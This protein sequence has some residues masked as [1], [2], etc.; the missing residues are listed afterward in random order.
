MPL[1]SATVNAITAQLQATTAKLAAVADAIDVSSETLAV[2]NTD[3]TAHPPIQAMIDAIDAVNTSDL[4]S[5]I[6]AHDTSTT[7]HEDIRTL[8]S[9]LSSSGG[10]AD[11]TTVT[12]DIA[13]AVTTHNTSTS[14][15]EDLRTQ[16]SASTTQLAAISS[17]IAAGSTS[18]DIAVHN[19]DPLAH[20]S[21][22]A[23]LS[24]INTEMEVVTA[25]SSYI[26]Q[27][28]SLFNGTLSTGGGSSGGGSSGSGAVSTGDSATTNANTAAI[29]TLEASLAGSQQAVN[30]LGSQMVN[31]T[32]ALS[33]QAVA[34]KQLEINNSFID[35]GVSL[36]GFADTLASIVA[37]GTTVSMSMGGT[38]VPTGD[39]L[40]YSISPAASGFTFSKT[41]GIAQNEVFQ[42]TIP[43]NA[44]AGQVEYFVVTAKLTLAGTTSQV[45]VATMIASEPSLTGLQSLVPTLVEPGLNYP[46]QFG[47][48][49]DP[50]GLA[51]SYSLAPVTGGLTFSKTTGIVNNEVVT[52]TVPAGLARGAAATFNMSVTN[53]LNQTTTQLFT[54]AA[55]TQP[56][57]STLYSNIPSLLVPGKAYSVE[58]AGGASTDGSAFTYSIAA[59]GGSPITFSPAAGITP[60]T[61]VVMTV[62]STVTRGST[63]QIQIS[64]VTA[65]GSVVEKTISVEINQLPDV[66]NVAVSLP[67]SVNGQST[68]P[69]T[70][71]GGVDPDGNPVTYNLVNIDPALGFSETG[72]IAEATSINLTA[73]YVGT[74]VD[75]IFGVQAIDSCGELSPTIK[76]VT[77]GIVPVTAGASAN[78]GL[79]SVLAQNFNAFTFNQ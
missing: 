55:T 63:H 10:D 18:P 70:I 20:P 38:T 12:N 32:S 50:D 77:V 45:S 66:S 79:M 74:A 72:G 61:N 23:A 67:A 21:I 35:Q 8:I 33:A 78:G 68:T 62:P 29:A 34:N 59:I 22:L 31:M 40:T 15:H 26:G 24:T 30:S 46:I 19:S 73:P 25:N 2:H 49:I 3:P 53:S 13:A 27:L 9:N 36:T 51:I 5:A 44:A 16:I 58:L 11:M 14:A 6:T 60:T 57:V 69:F 4:T 37:P 28:A 56:N 1:D 17:A 42:V 39:T 54:L 48:A 43:A 64:L 71:S 7:A 41:T 76:T 47:G 75:C 52:M 65:V